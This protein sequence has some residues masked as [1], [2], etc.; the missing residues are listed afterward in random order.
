MGHGVCDKWGERIKERGG[1]SESQ[2]EKGGCRRLER[3]GER[4]K[5]REPKRR[6]TGERL[7]ETTRP[8]RGW[9]Q[10]GGRDGD[11]MQTEAKT[12]KGEGRTERALK[13]LGFQPLSW[14]TTG[15]PVCREDGQKR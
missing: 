5:R 1:G 14:E 9:S 3:G 10:A 12:E 13:A 2:E 6:D 11:E 7:A 4:R 8:W 15:K